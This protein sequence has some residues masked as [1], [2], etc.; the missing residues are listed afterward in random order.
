MLHLNI[1]LQVRNISYIALLQSVGGSL[2]YLHK[3]KYV[4]AKFERIRHYLLNHLVLEL[5]NLQ[6]LLQQ[7]NLL[8]IFSKSRSS[9]ESEVSRPV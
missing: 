1:L 6:I 4:L 9:F 2:F 3:L 5:L 8:S 7:M